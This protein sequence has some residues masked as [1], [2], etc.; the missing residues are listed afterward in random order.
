M[1]I[2]AIVTGYLEYLKELPPKKY[3]AFCYG[4]YAVKNKALNGYLGT[5]KM[6]YSQFKKVKEDLDELDVYIEMNLE[7]PPKKAAP[8]KRKAPAVEEDEEW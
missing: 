1:N 5:L 3:Y 6:P 7:M 2:D 4:T 8:V